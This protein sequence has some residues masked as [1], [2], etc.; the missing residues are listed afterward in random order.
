MQTTQAEE[1]LKRHREL[2]QNKPEL[3]EIYHTYYTMIKN[4]CVEGHTLEIGGGSGNFKGYFPSIIATDIVALPWLDI[5]S[6][7]QVLPFRNASIANIVMIDV[8]HHIENPTAFFRE[9]E[10][11]LKPGGRMILLE[12]AITPVSR[13]VLHFFHPEP[14]DM[15]QNPLNKYPADSE[16]EPF[17]ANQAVPTLLFFRYRSSLL[18]IIPSFRIVELKYH[19]LFVYPLSGGFRSWCLVPNSLLRPLCWFEQR[20]MPLLGSMMAFRLY[21][22]MEKKPDSCSNEA[23]ITK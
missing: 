19:D 22:I 9:V 15:G 5:I 1:C 10:R 7:A 18:E 6:D 4:D 17:D 12:P 20:L 14:I 2:W 11:I 21:C 16:R 23:L 13:I 8:L 3:R